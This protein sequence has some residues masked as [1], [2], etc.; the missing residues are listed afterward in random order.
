MCLLAA[1]MIAG[2]VHLRDSWSTYS[3]GAENLVV[4]LA[5]KTRQLMVSFRLNG[6]KTDVQ[7]HQFYTYLLSKGQDLVSAVVEE[8]ISGVS[9]CIFTVIV[10]LVYVVFGL[11]FPL[12]IGGKAGAL[13]R[14]YLWKKTFVS[15]L[16]AFWV[17]ILFV[18]L[19]N[20]MAIFFGL[21]SFF[22]NYVPEVGTIMAMVLPA[23]FIL[24]DGRL[25]SPSIILAEATIGQFVLKVIFNNIV[26][27][28]LIR[29]DREMSIHPVWVFLGINYFG[30]IWGPIG[31]MISVPILSVVKSSALLMIDLAPEE[32][33]D[34]TK[35]WLQQFLACL[36]GRDSTWTPAAQ[37][38]KSKEVKAE[39]AES[40]QP[41]E[42]AH[43]S[44]QREWSV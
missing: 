10:V 18:Y 40:D 5:E 44:D 36:E 31:M 14:S 37:R 39:H 34:P 11:F 8:I 21:V 26:E 30:Y 24:L 2:A 1:S 9:S 7:I 33:G 16:Y 29:D 38:K 19:H 25:E 23:P 15:L 22:L 6:T 4:W 27:A 28:K 12:P 32:E 17:S 3:Q 41:E 20:D 13:V 35:H 43:E 42:S